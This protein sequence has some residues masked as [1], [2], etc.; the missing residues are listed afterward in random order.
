MK[1]YTVFKVDEQFVSATLSDSTV[2]GNDNIVVY[3]GHDEKTTIKIEK[4]SNMYL[5]NV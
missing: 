2:F 3:P 5:I 1:N 4:K